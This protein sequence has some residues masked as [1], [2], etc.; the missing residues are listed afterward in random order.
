MAHGPDFEQRIASIIGFAP[1]RT[2]LFRQ[3]LTH[4]SSSTEHY[5]RLEFLGDR[6]LGLVI[7]DALFHRFPDE[8]EGKLSSRHNALVS[9]ETCAMIARQTGLPDLVELGAQATSDGVRTSDNVA[10]D[11]VEAVIGAIHV[12]AGLDAARTFILTHWEPLIAGQLSAPKHP[13]SALQEWAAANNRRP[14][15]YSDVVRDGPPHAPRFSV[16]ARIG[17]LAEATGE[18]PSKHAA[19][20]A[21]ATALLAIVSAPLSVRKPLRKGKST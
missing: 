14:P 5:Q 7:S 13:K 18:G 6:V 15:D 12:D 2:E 9:R 4:G 21:A 16:T 10:A 1:T 17:S 20:T 19:E 3:A 8:P 11:V